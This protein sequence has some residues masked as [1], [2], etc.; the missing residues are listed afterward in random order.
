L[1]KLKTNKSLVN[2]TNKEEG[3]SIAGTPSSFSL[4]YVGLSTIDIYLLRKRFTC[5]MAWFEAYKSINILK[6]LTKLMGWSMVV[7]RC[8]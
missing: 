7:T 4:K 8:N 5:A 2:Y 6:Y 3:V 1:I